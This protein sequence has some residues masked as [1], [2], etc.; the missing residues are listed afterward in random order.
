[1]EQITVQSNVR[2]ETGKG[3]NR[4]LRVA[5]K[6]LR[7]FT[8]IRARM[9]HSTSIRKKFSKFYIQNPVKIRFFM[10]DRFL[11]GKLV[12]C[13]IKEYQLE[14]YHHRLLHADFYEVAM[15]EVS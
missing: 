10:L 14:P 7:C 15:D 3:P 2:E 9:W 13:L 11:D 6:Y 1:M 5:G 4:R 12:N 8:D